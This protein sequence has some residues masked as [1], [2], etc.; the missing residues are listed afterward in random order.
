M[1]DRLTVTTKSDRSCIARITPLLTPNFLKL[2]HTPAIVPNQGLSASQMVGLAILRSQPLLHGVVC[3]TIDN[4]RTASNTEL[5]YCC[6]T[7]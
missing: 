2:A 3:P 1:S 7:E 4:D 5:E 6:W